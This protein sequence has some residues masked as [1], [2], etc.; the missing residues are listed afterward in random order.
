MGIII[1]IA[2]DSRA[3]AIEIS[4]RRSFQDRY[5]SDLQVAL[6]AGSACVPP[7]VYDSS[8]SNVSSFLFSGFN[9]GA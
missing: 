9:R 5:A 8:P 2:A 1:G 4:Q 6:D 3:V 7:P